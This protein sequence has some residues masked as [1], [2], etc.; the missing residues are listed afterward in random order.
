MADGL[1][2]HSFGMVEGRRHD[3]MIYCLSRID[4][5]L[6]QKLALSVNQKFLYGNATCERKPQI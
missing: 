3:V 5:Q 6:E 1:F 2:I 4:T